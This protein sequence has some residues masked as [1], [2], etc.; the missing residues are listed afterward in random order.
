VSEEANL[1]GRWTGVYFYPVDPE[2]NPDDDLPPTPFTAELRDVGGHVTGATLEADVFGPP[3]A[4]AIPATLD[5]HHLDGRLTFTKFPNGG[6][7]VHSID[8]VGSIAGDGNSVSGQWIIHGEWSGTFRMQRKLARTGA[9][10]E[11]T[12]TVAG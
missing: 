6:G 12:T 7:Q 9:A 10:L 5:G 11:T 4:P 8:Y 1:T 3:D 2:L